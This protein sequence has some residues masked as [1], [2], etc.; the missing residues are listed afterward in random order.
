[1][2]NNIGK[3]IHVARTR[4]FLCVLVAVALSGSF[5]FA[6][7]GTKPLKLYYSA[8]TGDNYSTASATGE[9]AAQSA[10][11]QFFRVEG[12]I[13]SNKIGGTVPLK[14]YYNF[15]TE[16]TMVV[17]TAAGDADAKAAGYAYI[18][19]EGYV[20]AQAKAG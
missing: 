18:W 3:R 19:D 15:V 7:P 20:Y 4:R 2:T 11:Y 16:D 13:Y 12:Y 9:A 5:A 1:M 6:D 17:A 10:F 8:L 14:L